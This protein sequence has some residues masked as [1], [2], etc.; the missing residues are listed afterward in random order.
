MKK[1]FKAYFSFSRGE[2]RGVLVLCII[3]ILTII[4][5]RMVVRL[6]P[7]DHFDIGP[8][9]A[10]IDSLMEFSARKDP[11][12]ARYGA[13]ALF[14]F[15]PNTIT[16]E[17]WIRLGLSS[18]QIRV[19]RNYRAKGG[20]FRCK[21]DLRKIYSIPASL[22]DQL[23]PYIKISALPSA[24]S[25]Y[26]VQGAGT[27]VGSTSV[28]STGKLVEINGADSSLLESLKGIG[29]V[30]ASRI[31][32]FRER[33]G[34]F[35]DLGQLKDVYGVDS[36]LYMKMVVQLK[37]NPALIR[38]ININ[39]SNIE[40]LKSGTILTYKQAR[41][42]INFREQHGPFSSIADLFKVIALDEQIIRKIEPYLEFTP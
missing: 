14:N 1:Y 38:K 18:G 30:L 17:D 3:L 19:I 23:A 10:E 41:A 22:Y 4:I 13:M 20:R 24:P 16:D 28:S 15:D 29:P 34:G 31:V 9:K 6:G 33:I 26:Y 11:A 37:V 36:S 7:A 39:R 40:E 2:L 8:Y 27:Y 21:E 32:R 35:Y 25:T 12:A 42:V 5:P